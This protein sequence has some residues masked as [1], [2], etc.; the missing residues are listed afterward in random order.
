MDGAA[1]RTCTKCGIPK[2]LTEFHK[3]ITDAEYG[4]QRRCKDCKRADNNAWRKANPDKKK[5][6]RARNYQKHRESILARQKEQR[7]GDD[8]RR[9]MRAYRKKWNLA[10]R[11]GITVA[12]LEALTLRQDGKCGVCDKRKKRMVVDH[13][14]KTGFVRGL[15]C[16]SC[17]VGLGLLGDTRSGLMRALKYLKQAKHEHNNTSNR[18]EAVERCGQ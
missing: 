4:L 1:R 10:N 17:N 9:Y 12:D 18:G 13:D 5:A 6:Q 2:P 3:N 7:S 14:H 15:L 11:Y 16:V 8:S